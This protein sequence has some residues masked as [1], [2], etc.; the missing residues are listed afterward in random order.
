MSLYP[1]H[2]AVFGKCA[3]TRFSRCEVC[4]QLTKMISD[5]SLSLDEKLGHVKT[6]RAHLHAQYVDRSVQWCLN[7]LSRDAN[8]GVLTILVDGLDQAKFR[9]PKHPSLRASAAMPFGKQI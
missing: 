2:V 6:Y 8:S 9:I 4:Y 7:D 1:K 5:R 3:P